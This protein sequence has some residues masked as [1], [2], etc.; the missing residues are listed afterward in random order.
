MDIYGNQLVNTIK[1]EP[2]CISLSNLAEVLTNVR[3]WTLS[4]FLGQRS[5]LQWTYIK[6]SL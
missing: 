3:G 4:F 6:I 1:T 5:R 2:L